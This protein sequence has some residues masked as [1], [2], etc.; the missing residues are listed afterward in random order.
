MFNK[1]FTPI[2]E[3]VTRKSLGVLL[4]A[5]TIYVDSTFAVAS[6]AS[7][8]FVA[9]VR[10]D[11]LE[12][13]LYSLAQ[14]LLQLFLPIVFLWSRPKLPL[15]LETWMVIGYSINLIVPIWGCIGLAD[16]NFGFKVCSNFAVS[17][18]E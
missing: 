4:V 14:N 3:L 16:V 8:L 18:R 10:P 7:Q 17:Y 9:E 5:Y 11:A 12:Y 2:K 15:R 1:V 13:S 6:V